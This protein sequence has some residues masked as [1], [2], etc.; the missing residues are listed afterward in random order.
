MGIILLIAGIVAASLSFVPS[1]ILQYIFVFA[2]LAVGIFGVTIRKNPKDAI[3]Q[4]TYYS[5]LGFILVALSFAVAIWATGVAA[6]VNVLGFFL[7]LLGIVGFV[8]ALQVLNYQSPIPWKVVGLKLA[9]SAT[10][11]IG[12]AYILTMAG[13]AGYMA[14]LFMGL[15]FV[16]IGLTFIQMGRLTRN[17]TTS[18]Q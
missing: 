11:A 2:S 15:L 3:K 5:W 8:R 13:F 14:L 16:T 9:L 6:L 4:S 17:A 18:N 10:T 1:K 12:A 7:L